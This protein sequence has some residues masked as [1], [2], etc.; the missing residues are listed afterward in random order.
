MTDS[1]DSDRE[2]EGNDPPGIQPRSQDYLGLDVQPTTTGS[3]D[4]RGWWGLGGN[5]A[6]PSLDPF[7]S[8]FVPGTSQGP[9]D[10]SSSTLHNLPLQSAP[11]V[12]VP[13]Q[14]QRS[15]DDQQAIAAASLLALGR[16]NGAPPSHQAQASAGGGY[17]DQPM[18]QAPNT[19]TST[20]P[21]PQYQAAQY[22]PQQY[23][24]PR[25]QPPQYQ[26]PQY[27]PPQYQPAQYQVPL[28]Q[29]PPYQAPPY[30]AP[31]WLPQ[32][33]QPLGQGQGAP[34]MPAVNQPAGYQQPQGMPINSLAFHAAPLDVSVDDR[35]R[36]RIVRGHY[37][38]FLSLIRHDTSESVVVMRLDDEGHPQN[39]SM[40]VP[41][42]KPKPTITYS[43][44]QKAFYVFATVWC[45]AYP[46]DFAHLLKYA[47]T[48]RELVYSRAKWHYYDEQFRRSR[49]RSFWP[50]QSLQMELW[51]KAMTLFRIDDQLGEEQPST[52]RYEPRPN[53]DRGRSYFR[54]S[55]GRQAQPSNQDIPAGY[56][57]AFNRGEQCRDNC[58]YTHKCHRC[59]G[60]HRGCFCPRGPA[61]GRHQFKNRKPPANPSKRR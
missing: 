38:D 56:C 1:E 2:D 23:Q 53:R 14:P 25:Y 27:Q 30:Q 29:A 46:H 47:E 51:G 44:W 6:E 41:Q 32:Q 8:R 52:P 10:P 19:V 59:D 17:P 9:A 37:I 24:P 21:Q 36:D 28:Y 31:Q 26:A 11:V 55:G 61:A 18:G 20:Q 39:Q 60:P 45:Q 12:A 42:R 4:T 58:R 54:A 22:Q 34:P 3:A 7:R 43:Q 5:H 48:I 16:Q 40:M 49:E 33:P 15:A 13:D 50:W 57:W 35:T